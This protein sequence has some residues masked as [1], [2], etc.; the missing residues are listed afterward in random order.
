MSNDEV[1][2][3]GF[4][5]PDVDLKSLMHKG[6]L[7]SAIFMRIHP[8]NLQSNDLNCEIS[9]YNTVCDKKKCHT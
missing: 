7:N 5:E 9:Q 4:I 3:M 6:R 8:T 2:S 1:P